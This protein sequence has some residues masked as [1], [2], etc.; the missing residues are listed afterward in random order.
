MAPSQLADTVETDTETA[1]V[2]DPA[3]DLRD[4]LGFVLR[5]AQVSAFRDLIE[6]LK[7]FDLRPTDFSVLTVVA[8]LPGLKQQAVGEALR[9]Q[10][11]N[12][13]AIIDQLEARGLV[14]RDPSPSDRRSHAL[15][16]TAAGES[17]LKQAKAAQSAHEARLTAALGDADREVVMT[18]LRRIADA[19]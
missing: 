9:V 17:L 3:G 4:Q 11:P 14:R 12:L 16:L 15:R 18:A 13:V 10:R 8:A 6:A 1:N 2:N 7:P 5:L 19:F